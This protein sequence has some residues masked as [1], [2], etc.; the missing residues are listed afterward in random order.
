M[1]VPT[2]YGVTSTTV[3]DEALASLQTVNT[4]MLD[5]AIQSAAADVCGLVSAANITPESIT[6]AAYPTDYQ[7]LHDTVTIGAAFYYLRNTTGSSDSSRSFEAQFATRLRM[8]R[9]TPNT[10]AAYN[11]NVAGANTILSHMSDKSQGAIEDERRRL[12]KPE[13]SPRSWRSL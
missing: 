12:L 5:A 8:L 9:D 6:L 7:R 4:S 2:T 11:S 13:A 10:L 1:A 3:Q